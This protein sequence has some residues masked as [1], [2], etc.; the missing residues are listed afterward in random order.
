MSASRPVSRFHSRRGAV[1][2]VALLLSAVIALMLGSYLSLNLNSTRQ[3]FRSFQHQA[4]ANL[5]EAGA[6]EALWAFNRA[7]AGHADAWSDWTINSPAAWRKFPDFD[8]TQ[9]TSGWVKVYVTP[10][11]PAAH[12]RPKII[13]YASVNPA[14]QSAVT[15]MME[16]TLRKRSL[17][18]SGLVAK[19]TI[20][21]N[22]AMTTVD[23]WNSDPDGDP[24]TAPVAYDETVRNDQGTVAS[25]AVHNSAALINQA[26]I[27]GY[28]FTGGQQPQVGHNGS[29]RGKDTAPEV[30]IDPGRIATDFNAD[31]PPVDAPTDGTYIAAIGSTLGVAGETTSWRCPSLSLSGNQ[32][33]TILGDVTLV[34]TAPSGSDALSLTGKAT[35]IIPAGS[36]LRLYTEGNIKVAGNG[37][38][39]PNVQPLSC[40]IWGTNRSAAGQIIRVAGNGVLCGIV[41]APE[42]EITLNGNGDMMGSVVGRTITLTGNAAFHYDESLADFG[43]NS[44][45]G[46]SRWR[47]L[48]TAE[49]RGPYQA[50]FEGW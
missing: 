25:A 16:V 11:R 44:N 37:I 8:F 31:F 48:T 39:N 20:T 34:L 47:E 28:V 49:E 29:I 24:A 2:I 22:G 33:L 12:D 5:V 30:A 46:I 14:N 35:I 10:H 4:A 45:F 38:T 26:D 15:R 41:Y 32:S 27:W 23:S 7:A 42:A 6:E 1:L 43:D 13:T 36:R 50:L 9:N 17:F 3:A 18:A 19:D 21:F 40:Q